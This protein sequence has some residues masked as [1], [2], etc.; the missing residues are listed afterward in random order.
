LL[1]LTGCETFQ[2]IRQERHFP[3]FLH[4]GRKVHCGRARLYLAHRRLLFLIAGFSGP[5]CRSQEVKI[6]EV[7][8]TT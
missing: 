8:R 4:E 3:A 7:L 5:D 1:D 6:G 2:D